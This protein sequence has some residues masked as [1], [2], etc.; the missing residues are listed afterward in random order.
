[1]E[2]IL[3][4]SLL[5]LFFGTFGTTLGGIIGINFKNPS[6]KILSFILSLASGLMIAVVCFELVP[7]ATNISNIPTVILGIIAGIIMM[8]FCDIFVEKKFNNKKIR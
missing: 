1:M 7:E 2:E 3:R 8:I 4:T 5:G 6:N